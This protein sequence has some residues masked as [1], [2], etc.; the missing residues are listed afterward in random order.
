[1]KNDK[2]ETVDD[3]SKGC[4]KM[5]PVNTNI[6][7]RYTLVIKNERATTVVKQFRTKKQKRIAQKG[8][9]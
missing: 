2:Q 8:E 5:E 7:R 4:E 6:N 9:I 1:M 3:I